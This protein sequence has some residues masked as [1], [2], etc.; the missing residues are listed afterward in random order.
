[1][2]DKTAPSGSKTDEQKQQ[3]LGAKNDVDA[4]AKAG[5]V[6]LEHGEPDEKNVGVNQ[7]SDD[8]WGTTPLQMRDNHS[9]EVDPKQVGTV[10][11]GVDDMPGQSRLRPNP[12]EPGEEGREDAPKGGTNAPA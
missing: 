12:M 1:M 7:L 3:Q 2:A 6:V 11:G 10:R 8:P 9:P 5:R 4:A